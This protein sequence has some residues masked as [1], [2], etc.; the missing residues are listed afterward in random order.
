LLS[1]S[2]SRI[3]TP[4]TLLST[5][6]PSTP[7]QRLRLHPPSKT[8][9]RIRLHLTTPRRDLSPTARNNTEN[10]NISTQAILPA[11]LFDDTIE[12]IGLLSGIPL[13]A[14]RARNVPQTPTPRHL[15]KGALIYMG[16]TGSNGYINEMLY[17]SQADLLETQVLDS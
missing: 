2:Q 4:S 7:G 16:E 17:K 8:P 5:S 11:S 3:P 10:M 9:S 14:Q 12:H 6:L 15:A 1:Y 13:G